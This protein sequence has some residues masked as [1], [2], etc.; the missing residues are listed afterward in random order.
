MSQSFDEKIAHKLRSSQ[1]TPTKEAK[2]ALFAKLSAQATS[3]GLSKQR[4]LKL[5]GLWLAQITFLLLWPLQVSEN[6]KANTSLTSSKEEAYAQNQKKIGT[7]IQNDSQSKIEKVTGI[8]PI[9]GSNGIKINDFSYHDSKKEE[10]SKLS[11]EPYSSVVLK[12]NQQDHLEGSWQD[13]AMLEHHYLTLLDDHHFAISIDSL[14]EKE[15]T[16][17]AKAISTE[18]KERFLSLYSNL[19]IF[20]LYQEMQPNVDDDVVIDNFQGQNSLSLNRLGLFGELGVYRQVNPSLRIHLGTTLNMYNQK[21]SFDVRSTQPSEVIITGSEN[22]TFNPI[23]ES[24]QITMDHRLWVAGLKFGASFHVFPS[25]S[26]SVF[27]AVEYNHVLNSRHHFDFEGSTYHIQY[28]HQWL[29]TVGFRKKLWQ[30]PRGELAL[31]PNIRYSLLRLDPSSNEALSIKPFSIGM[32][33]SYLI[34]DKE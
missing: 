19:G 32:T 9:T 13:L 14:P 23:F 8:L 33:L 18:K 27:T 5:I 30:V 3:T 15:S 28:P 16:I 29:V 17:K 2:E 10:A 1:S 20:F 24:D 34:Q 12:N 7:A 31:I 6:S 21:Y 26:N 22:Q 25:K 11:P 4:R